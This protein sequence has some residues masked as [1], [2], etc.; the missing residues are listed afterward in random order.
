MTEEWR[1]YVAP[2]R[3][4]PDAVRDRIRTH[5]LGEVKAPGG[6]RRT[7]LAV[8]AG[9]AL[10][11]A[12]GSLAVDSLAGVQAP[13]NGLPGPEIDMT[14]AQAELDRC[15][16]AV[17]DA[18]KAMRF[19]H[20]ATWRPVI[21]WQVEGRWIVAARSDETPIIC[22][23]TTTS[24]TVS[25]PKGL[26][27]AASGT[28]TAALLFTPAGSIAGVADPAWS[29][30]HV[31]SDS[32]GGP[33]TA[34]IVKDGL[35][36]GMNPLPRGQLRVSANF[37]GQGTSGPDFR[38]LPAPATPAVS[39][40]DRPLPAGER[41]S[42]EGRFL[43][44]CLSSVET[45]VSDPDAWQPGA[46]ASVGAD[47]TVMA[48]LGELVA[49]CTGDFHPSGGERRFFFTFIRDEVMLARPVQFVTVIKAEPGEGAWAVGAVQPEVAAMTM[50]AKPGDAPVSV[51]IVRSTF[52]VPIPEELVPDLQSVPL[53]IN[54][55]LTDR[56]GKQ[57][58]SGQ[59]FP[60]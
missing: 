59:L 54:V 50:T 57:I 32:P 25:D 55:V 29:T 38:D 6:R 42:H 5:A 26:A 13:A 46:M 3:D 14:R 34:A 18:G 12:A 2:R 10:L 23:T 44:E 15:W 20:R 31:S 39:V 41:A 9:V 22:E 8:A 28:G 35:W 60:G 4:L 17:V 37:P 58:R 53:G 7:P 48:R 24:V 19:P 27:P 49:Y 51:P 43:G 47:Q 36:V 11:V 52:A 33:A 16:A 21:G 56:D 45:P 1:P 40:V 30:L